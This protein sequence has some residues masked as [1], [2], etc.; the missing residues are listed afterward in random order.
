[1]SAF[2][3]NLPP[4]GITTPQG[5][6]R[7]SDTVAGLHAFAV[8]DEDL[9]GGI[10]QDI[11]HSAGRLHSQERG[12]SLLNHEKSRGNCEGVIGSP[13]ASSEEVLDDRSRQKSQA[14]TNQNNATDPDRLHT[15]LSLILG[16]SDKLAARTA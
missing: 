16:S 3:E 2:I 11:Y 1:M 15:G 10:A 14:R 13:A 9:G 5:S 8:Y 4:K 7:V 12:P 6:R